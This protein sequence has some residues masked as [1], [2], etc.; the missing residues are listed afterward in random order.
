[1]NLNN[2]LKPLLLL[3]KLDNSNIVKAKTK[4][5]P[6]GTTPLLKLINPAESDIM[7]CLLYNLLCKNKHATLA[8]QQKKTL[9]AKI[10]RKKYVKRY[11]KSLRLLQQGPKSILDIVGEF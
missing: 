1:M 3:R 2:C 7:Q 9:Q 6:N 5:K 10:L 4:T 8:L 11:R